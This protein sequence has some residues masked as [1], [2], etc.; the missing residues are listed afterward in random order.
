MT[1]ARQWLVLTIAFML[2]LIGTTILLPVPWFDNRTVIEE[3]SDDRPEKTFHLVTGEFKSEVN[4][5]EIEAYRWDPGSIVVH[6]GD[7]V[8]L[9][10]RGINGKTHHFSLK[11]FGVSGVIRKGETTKVSFVADQAGTFELICHDH[12]TAEA[13][14]PMIAYITVLEGERE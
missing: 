9:I 3:L 8:N 14:G 11:E 10:L 2:V 5:K 1:T 12:S 4:G 13:N 6:K 7:K